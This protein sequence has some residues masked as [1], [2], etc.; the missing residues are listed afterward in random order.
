MTADPYADRTHD[1]AGEPLCNAWESKVLNAAP[2]PGLFAI[3]AEIT[4]TA[5]PMPQ[6]MRLPDYELQEIT[7]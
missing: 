6:F 2:M 3:A 4:R 5:A 7:D 1:D